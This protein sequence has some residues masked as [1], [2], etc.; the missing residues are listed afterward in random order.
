MYLEET[1]KNL[2]DYTV[3]LFDLWLF[4][5]IES[6]RF[7]MMMKA[8]TNSIKRRRIYSVINSVQAIIENKKNIFKFKY[9]SS[10]NHVLN[11]YFIKNKFD[12]K[13]WN[14]KNKEFS[15]I[16]IYFLY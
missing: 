12:K 7:E 2:K 4:L 6:D 11:L 10:Y 15:Y 16:Y 13:R 14:Q 5:N 1:W 8:N 9:F 3:V